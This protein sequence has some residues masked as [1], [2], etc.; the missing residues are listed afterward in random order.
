ML[1][2]FAFIPARYDSSVVLGGLLPGGIAAD[3]WTFVTSAEYVPELM[4]SWASLKDIS[5]RLQRGSEL[6]PLAAT[7]GESDHN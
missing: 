4:E 2:N 7:A 6:P 1:L 5:Q 3:I